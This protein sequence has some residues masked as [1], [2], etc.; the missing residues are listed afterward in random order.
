V[1]KDSF[2]KGRFTIFPLIMPGCFGD[3]SSPIALGIKSIKAPEPAP[4]SR[5]FPLIYFDD[6]FLIIGAIRSPA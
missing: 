3:K 5:T 1:S 4:T 2:S 6:K